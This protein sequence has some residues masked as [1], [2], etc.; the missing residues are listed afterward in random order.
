MQISPYSNGDCKN[1]DGSQYTQSA[2]Q[3]YFQ[4]RGPTS[5]CIESNIT[6]NRLQF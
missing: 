1:D 2:A 4:K 5:R 6:W 3:Y